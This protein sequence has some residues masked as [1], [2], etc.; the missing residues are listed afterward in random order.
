MAG[1]TDPLHDFDRLLW[2]HTAAP[3]PDTAPL[4]GEA[5]AD[6][7]V[8]GAGY[9]GLSTALHLAGLGVDVCVLEAGHVGEGGSGRNA[10]HCNPTFMHHSPDEVSR[11]LGPEHGE[12]MTRLQA[13]AGG[14]LYDLV[15]R[16][17]IDCDAVQNGVVIAAHV[18]EKLPGLEH[19]CSLYAREVPGCRMLDA[20]EM[21]DITGSRCYYGGWIHPE[22]GHLNPLGLVRGLARAALAA[23]ARLHTDSAV[24]T[25]ARESGGWRL[26]TP[27]GS[28]RAARV[29]LATNAYSHGL[30]PGLERSYF[31]LQ[32]FNLASAP[33]GANERADVL[34]GGHNVIDTRGDKHYYLVDRDG[35]FVTGTLVNWGRG[36]DEALTHEVFDRRLAFLF[37]QLPRLRWE[38]MWAGW[39]SM[40]RSMLPRIFALAP[41]L[42]AVTGFSGRGVPTGTALGPHLADWLAGGDPRELPLPVTPLAT[43]PGGRLLDWLVPL[44]YAPFERWRD[45]RALRRAGVEPPRL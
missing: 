33:L 1:S 44:V 36:R 37:P 28:L 30:W 31:R 10:G 40:N 42:H 17:R 29:L 20:A 23:G 13:R 34:P 27:G 7:A 22:G 11:L 43:I 5:R 32:P 4:A 38:W 35:R 9:T 39:L 16:H 21:A 25:M 14:F 45:A 15:R 12:R 8:V 26:A 3:A 2:A 6:V 19:A 41:G 24:K 18:P